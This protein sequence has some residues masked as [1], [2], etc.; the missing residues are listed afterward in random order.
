MLSIY[1][2]PNE[3]YTTQIEVFH[4]YNIKPSAVMSERD[5]LVYKTMML[6]SNLSKIHFLNKPNHQGTLDSRL[7]YWSNGA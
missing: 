5:S 2:D 4:I 1:V 7:T 6:C 3:N